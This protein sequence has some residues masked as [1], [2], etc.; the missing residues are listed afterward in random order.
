M[1]KLHVKCDEDFI[2]LFLWI[3]YQLKYSTNDFFCQFTGFFDILCPFL[4]GNVIQSKITSL[5]SLNNSKLCA[6]WTKLHTFLLTKHTLL[7]QIFSFTRNFTFICSSVWTIKILLMEHKC[8][9]DIQQ[10]QFP[11]LVIQDS[12][13][14]ALICYTLV[15]FLDML[16]TSV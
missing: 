8:V 5:P 12:D 3:Q 4:M 13:D 7:W 11:N 14:S 10:W 16:A 2:C 9:V 6:W 15:I 1:L